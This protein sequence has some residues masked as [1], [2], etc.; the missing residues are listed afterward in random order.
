MGPKC[1][2]PKAMWS[3]RNILWPATERMPHESF[4]LFAA[5]P[6]RDLEWSDQGIEG[7]SR[8]LHRV[9]RLVKSL[10]PHMGGSEQE[11]KDADLTMRRIMHLTIKK[12]THDVDERFNF[13]TA[14]SAIM[15]MVNAL[16]QYR[17]QN[18]VLNSAVVAE[19][20]NVLPLLLAPFA[21]HLAEELWY[22]L[23]RT[24]SVHSQ[25]WPVYDEGMI[26]QDEVEIVVQ[27]NGKVRDRVKVPV[28]AS[29]DQT[30]S[31]VMDQKKVKPYVEG[32]DIVKVIFVP[33]KLM[34]LVVQ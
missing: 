6:E 15:E 31:V 12:V 2:N 21:P 26:V 25:A 16:Y 28:G 18:V 34:N 20:L 32:K 24:E 17:D 33:E 4:I 19:S 13:N 23:G 10:K 22:Q 8:F 30:R 27:V 14:I 11:V 29:E 5:P 7:S 1:P 3:V 9:W